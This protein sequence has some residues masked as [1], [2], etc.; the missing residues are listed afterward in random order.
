[1]FL[2]ETRVDFVFVYLI[3]FLF[4]AIKQYLNI[5][6]HYSIIEIEKKCFKRI[7]SIL[8]GFSHATKKKFV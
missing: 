8:I 6:L 7:V 2:F 3:E 1:M 4:S 5:A